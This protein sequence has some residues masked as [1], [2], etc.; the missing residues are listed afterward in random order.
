MFACCDR[1]RAVP[2]EARA[3]PAP[4][5]VSPSPVGLRLALAVSAP[6]DFHER[7]ASRVADEV[8]RRPGAAAQTTGSPA[9]VQRRCAC[10]GVAGADGECA[11]CKAKRLARGAAPAEMPSGAPPHV[12][13][14]LRG[15]GRPLDP[16]VREDMETRFGHDFAGVRIHT[17]EAASASAAS[18]GARAYTLGTRIAF[19]AGQYAPASSEGR[20]LVAHELT[21]VL[22]QSASRGGSTIAREAVAVTPHEPSLDRADIVTFVR[23]RNMGVPCRTMH[24]RGGVGC[25]LVDCVRATTANLPFAIS[26]GVCIFRCPDGTVC[27]CVLLGSSTSAICVLTFCDPPGSVSSAGDYQGLADRAV[28]QA[29]AQMPAS[30]RAGAAPR[31]SA[32][33]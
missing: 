6:G 27:A 14:A 33:A 1:A 30:D 5:R 26:P 17:D 12:Q 19:A 21:H 13:A 22:Q 18:L 8:M 29:A 23:C 28:A 3:R 24:F 4:T 11:A 10:G 32:A 7:E 9:Q 15:A 2:A 16:A 31:E 25:P 20:H